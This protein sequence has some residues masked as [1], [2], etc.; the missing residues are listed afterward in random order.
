[1][2][3]LKKF[4]PQGMRLRHCNWLWLLFFLSTISVLFLRR[5]IQ[6]LHSLEILI[7]LLTSIWGG[8]Y[9]LHQQNI[10]KARFFKELVTDFNRRYDDKN[11]DLLAIIREPNKPLDSKQIQAVIDYFNLCAEEYLFYDA[12]Y[13]DRR[14]W[15][16]WYNGMKQFGGDS[17]ISELWRQEIQQTNSYYEFQFPTEND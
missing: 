3:V 4:K 14:V 13:I 12:G 8:F 15:D 5:W 11:N 10:E 7:P 17:R 9:F 2:N 6:C 1:M 16:A